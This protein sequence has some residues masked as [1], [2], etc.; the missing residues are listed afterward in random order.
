MRAV[1]KEYE[2][3]VSKLDAQLASAGDAAE[4][5]RIQVALAAARDELKMQEKGLRWASFG[6]V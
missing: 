2:A 3:K 5:E 6:A 4:R 1:R